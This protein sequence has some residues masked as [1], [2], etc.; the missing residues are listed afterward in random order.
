MRI[1]HLLIKPIVFSG[2]IS[3]VFFANGSVHSQTLKECKDYYDQGLLLEEVYKECQQKAI[4][5]TP[6]KP[7]ADLG[8]PQSSPKNSSP[9]NSF[10][11]LS[12]V[13]NVKQFD[14]EG[15]RQNIQ[16]WMF[17]VNGNKVTILPF[18]NASIPETRIQKIAFNNPHLYFEIPAARIPVNE[19]IRRTLLKLPHPPP[20]PQF[21]N[22]IAVFD[23]TRSSAVTLEGISNLIDETH[24]THP[25]FDQLVCS[26]RKNRKCSPEERAT[27][28]IQKQV[29]MT[30][31]K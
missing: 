11:F 12:G 5:I 23:L 17:K 15:N 13:W 8:G 1:F 7:L 24:K 27:P 14:P 31:L 22:F 28:V 16:E 9:S 21:N 25:E 26:V 3:F 20:I 18:G 2:G 6:S 29:I 10:E 30:K 4:G 19:G